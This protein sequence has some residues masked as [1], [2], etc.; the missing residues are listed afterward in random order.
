[1]ESI[2]DAAT[3][4]W[5]HNVQGDNPP[6]DSVP[7]IDL[8]KRIRR[9][10]DTYVDVPAEL[11]AS[12]LEAKDTRLAA[13]KT[14]KAFKQDLLA[15][16]GTAEGGK[17]ETGQ[18]TFLQQSK[19]GFDVKGLKEAHPDLAKLFATKSV[20]RVLRFKKNKGKAIT[21]PE[22]KAMAKG[23]LEEL[24]KMRDVGIRGSKCCCLIRQEWGR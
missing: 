21:L 2:I 1:M 24:K 15:K 14:E 4:F 18:V 23:R 8:I 16:L 17:C 11:V 6:D 5:E 9:V 13:E 7:S 10:P 20:Y 22:T 3:Y 19:A 12:W